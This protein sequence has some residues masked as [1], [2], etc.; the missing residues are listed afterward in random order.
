MEDRKVKI[1]AADVYNYGRVYCI[2]VYNDKLDKWVLIQRIKNFEAAKFYAT[3]CGTIV[4]INE[5][6]N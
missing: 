6:V 3:K 4:E 2:K 1:E 5:M